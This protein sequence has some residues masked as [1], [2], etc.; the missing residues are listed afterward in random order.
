MPLPPP[1]SAPLR[2]VLVEDSDGY[3]AL[4]ETLLAASDRPPDL[5]RFARLD[6]ALAHLAH[7]PADCVLLDLEL[8]DADGTTTLARV[9]EVAPTVPVVVL[10]GHAGEALASS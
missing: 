1:M 9:L 10:T 5:R 3:A 8:P 6:E 7:V 2:L 4:I